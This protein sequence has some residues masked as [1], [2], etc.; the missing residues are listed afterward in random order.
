M[1]REL[2]I[3]LAPICLIGALKQIDTASTVAIEIGLVVHRLSCKARHAS[4]AVCVCV[5]FET[6]TEDMQSFDGYRRGS[7]VMVSVVASQF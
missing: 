2:I 5:S 7:V 1:Q 6:R 4:A 3:L